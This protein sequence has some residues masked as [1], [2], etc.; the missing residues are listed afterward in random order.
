M[1]E[2]PRTRLVQTPLLFLA[3]SLAIGIFVGHYPPS[4][5]SIRLGAAGI[6]TSLIL[7]SVWMVSRRESRGAAVLVLIAFFVAGFAIALIANQPDD[8]NRIKQM[9]DGGLMAANE[10]IELTAVVHGQP[11]SAPEGFYLNVRA[12]TVRSRFG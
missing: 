7:I 8:S 2:L 1:I 10:P 5:T 9:F 3:V 6:T 12:E 4:A 11:E